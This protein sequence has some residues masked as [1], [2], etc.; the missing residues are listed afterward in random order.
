MIRILTLDWT[1]VSSTERPK[2]QGRLLRYIA[3]HGGMLSEDNSVFVT[4]GVD[5]EREYDILKRLFTLN[6]IAAYERVNVFG[7]DGQGRVF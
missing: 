1:K 3:G 7:F 2:A 5:K 6:N 4:E